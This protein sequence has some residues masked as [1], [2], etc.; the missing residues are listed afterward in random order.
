MKKHILFSLLSGLLST[1]A[2]AAT[3]TTYCPPA[4]SFHF[5]ADSGQF[6]APGDWALNFATGNIEVEKFVKVQAYD[7]GEIMACIY[8]VKLDNV[9]MQL[10]AFADDEYYVAD[11]IHNKIW[12]TGAYGKVCKTASPQACKF[13]NE[14]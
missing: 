4:K 14:D 9:G 6:L 7:D 13:H 3:G 10:P 8:D 12:H 2:L 11:N 5:E 1:T